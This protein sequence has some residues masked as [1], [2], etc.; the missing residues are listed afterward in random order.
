[1]KI[2]VCVK[3]VPDPEQYDKI[4]I[5]PESKRLVR[6]GIPSVLNISDRHAIEA[7]LRLKERHGGEIVVISMGP[8]MAQVQLREALAMGADSAFLLSDRKVGGA[9]T[10]ATSYALS[11]MLKKIGGVDLVLA[12]NESADGATSHV[13]SQLGEWLGFSHTVNALAID[14]EDDAHVL[15]TK[16]MDDGE[17]VYRLSMPSVIAVNQRCNQVRLTSAIAVLKAKNKPLT[18]W[19]AEDLSE[20]DETYIGLDGSPSK[21]GE[22]HTIEA[23]K[24]CKMLEGSEDEAAAAVVELI[25]PLLRA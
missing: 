24:N 23:T 25:Q 14:L 13:P 21:N 12:G 15:V 18:V 9:D 2:A 11:V 20:L 6:D 10:L 7:A 16:R 1:M 8:P 17:A 4:L 19:S 5:D 22:L 3:S